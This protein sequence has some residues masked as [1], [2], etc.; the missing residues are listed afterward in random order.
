MEGRYLGINLSQGLPIKEENFLNNWRIGW[1]K[2]LE[3]K[4]GPPKG[5]PR[6]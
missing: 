6:G 2:E 5:F 1:G 4:K 3:V